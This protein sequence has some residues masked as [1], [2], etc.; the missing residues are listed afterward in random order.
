VSA[1]R[2]APIVAAGAVLIALLIALALPAGRSEGGHGAILKSRRAA[3]YTLTPAARPA[4]AVPLA[5][6][7]RAGLLFDVRSGAVLWEHD[8]L[9]HLRIASLTK[10]MTALIV[11]ERTTEREAVP[12]VA[13]A[14]H[15][16]GS[17]LGFLPVGRTLPVRT[18][19]YAMLLPS[20]NDAANELAVHVAGSIPAFVALMNERAQR[21]GLE[22]TRYAAPSGFFNQG[23]YSCPHDLALLAVRILHTPRLARIVRTARITLRFPPPEHTIELVNNNPLLVYRYPGTIGVKTGYT[24]EAGICLVA[25]VRRHGVTLGVVLLHSPA[26]GEQARKLFDWAYTQVYRQRPVPAPPAPPGF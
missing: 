16:G 3:A 14:L 17:R 4:P 7:P 8:P 11:A 20:A 5:R 10:M 25:A 24:E 18:L 13:S 12:I 2:A 23:N 6:L 9:R 21:W 22:C 26:I 15:V 19:L 1:R